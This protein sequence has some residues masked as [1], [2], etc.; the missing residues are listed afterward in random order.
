MGT[1]GLERKRRTRLL[2]GNLRVT[3]DVLRF[4]GVEMTED[5]WGALLKAGRAGAF[6][7]LYEQAHA[8][9]RER[10]KAC[11]PD[12]GGSASEAAR[13]NAEWRRLRH[14]LERVMA[15]AERW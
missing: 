15:K 3:H 9:Y 8:N 13:I 1:R 6:E 7:A 4:F 12:K 11:H 2:P 10:V 14:T 5:R